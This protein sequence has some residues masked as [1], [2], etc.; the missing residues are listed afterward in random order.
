MS[1]S[2]Y[3]ILCSRLCT[4]F[5]YMSPI[6]KVGPQELIVVTT[7]M[8]GRMPKVLEEFPRQTRE[9][10]RDPIGWLHKQ[11]GRKM[12][13][14]VNEFRAGSACTSELLLPYY[15]LRRR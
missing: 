4:A 15:F 14:R 9:T 7:R 12:P 1:L 13:N 8:F 11:G 6:P 3:L 2:M 5:E 10:L